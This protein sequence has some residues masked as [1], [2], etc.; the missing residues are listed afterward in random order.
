MSIFSRKHSGQND[1]LLW[2]L[3]HVTELNHIGLTTLI[4][5]DTGNVDDQLT[6]LN[7]VL[8][9]ENVLDIRNGVVS[10]YIFVIIEPFD[11]PHQAKHIEDAIIISEDVNI[12]IRPVT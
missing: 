11:P 1:I 5:G 10:T 8:G 3:I 4:D 7:Q 12:G 6:I 2:R 9:F